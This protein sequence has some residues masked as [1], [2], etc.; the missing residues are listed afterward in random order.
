M[1]ISKQ[2][3]EE[4]KVIVGQHPHM[5]FDVKR[6]GLI[7]IS[8]P[9]NDTLEIHDNYTMG[10]V[11]LRIKDLKRAPIS[12]Y[13]DAITSVLE[14]W[15]RGS[16]ILDYVN[17]NGVD[18]LFNPNNATLMSNAIMIY[19]P[20]NTELTID[21]VLQECRDYLCTINPQDPHITVTEITKYSAR[22]YNSAHMY[23]D[24]SLL[25][26]RGVISTIEV[27]V[28]S[29]VRGFVVAIETTGGVVYYLL[30]STVENAKATHIASKLEDKI[31]TADN[32]E[33]RCYTAYVS[34]IPAD[35][36]L[37]I[38][39]LIT[40]SY[41]HTLLSEVVNSAI[42]D[43]NRLLGSN[44]VVTHVDTCD[45][46]GE[47][48]FLVMSPQVNEEKY[49]ITLTQRIPRKL[50]VTCAANY[51]DVG[52]VNLREHRKRVPYNLNPP[53]SMGGG[54]NDFSSRRPSNPASTVEVIGKIINELGSETINTSYSVTGTHAEVEDFI[55][56]PGIQHGLPTVSL[57]PN[58]FTD[59]AYDVSP[60]LMDIVK[61][62]GD[63]AI[64]SIRHFNR[65]YA[66]TLSVNG[67][68]LTVYTSQTVS[69]DIDAPS[70]LMNILSRDWSSNDRDLHHLTVI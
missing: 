39:R 55:I 46:T 59:I 57:L 8:G 26:I 17:H 9:D 37:I 13:S 56:L 28:H 6:D 25:S 61:E 32:G 15:L 19:R 34:E 30:T 23:E 21:A 68:Q 4:L 36:D 38:S 50:P 47:M 33:V 62:H 53:G 65:V 48:I 54:G 63:V 69:F 44:Y 70:R 16:E 12:G 22:L 3:I 20:C 10:S 7:C 49:L 24:E 27:S 29:N 51:A 11:N 18:Y 66:I 31:R 58:D 42:L 5:A 45:G 67:H 41:R 64:F 2:S 40:L 35:D 43:I 52:R 1:K 60:L 14:K